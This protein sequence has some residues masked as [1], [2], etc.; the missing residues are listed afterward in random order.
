MDRA[1]ALRVGPKSAGAVPGPVCYGRGGS[2][3]TVTDCNL[4]LGYLDKTS[5]L[6]G[7]LP[8]D[9]GIYLETAQFHDELEFEEKL[10]ARTSILQYLTFQFFAVSVLWLFPV[11]LILRLVFTIKYIWVTPWFNV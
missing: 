1:G 10:L 11:K 4:L 2:E 8:I 3:P 5:L 6:D 9:I 7:E